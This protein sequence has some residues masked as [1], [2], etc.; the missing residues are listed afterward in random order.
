MPDMEQLLTILKDMTLGEIVGSGFALLFLSTGLIEITPIKL[1]P[2]T[3]ILS[4]IGNRMNGKLISKVDNL[5]E[6][7]D[8]LE[9]KID[10]NEIDRI[11]WEIL[12]FANSCRNGHRHTKDEFEHIIALHEKYNTILEEH[13]MQ[14]GLVTIEYGYIEDIYKHCLQKNSFV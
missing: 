14:N 13:D 10:M 5:E 2:L 11:R 3:A 8:A 1:N 9:K 6:K 4:W 12:N 7:T